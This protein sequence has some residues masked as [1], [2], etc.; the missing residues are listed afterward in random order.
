M[1][2]KIIFSIE[3]FFGVSAF[4]GTKNRTSPTGQE[5]V[6]TSGNKRVRYLNLLFI[7]VALYTRSSNDP[8]RNR[9]RLL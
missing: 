5:L 3:L 1:F 9:S 8:E 4:S 6:D 7:L 2:L